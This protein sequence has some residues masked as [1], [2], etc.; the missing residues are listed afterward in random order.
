MMVSDI[1]WLTT[2]QESGAKDLNAR[3]YQDIR[4][5]H[6]NYHSN[7]ANIHKRKAQLLSLEVQQNELQRLLHSKRLKLQDA[8]LQL[9]SWLNQYSMH[10]FSYQ[11]LQ[12]LSSRFNHE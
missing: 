6:N 2:L 1:E 12:Y 3:E 5:L 4:F 7:I 9:L 11:S 10:S 8:L